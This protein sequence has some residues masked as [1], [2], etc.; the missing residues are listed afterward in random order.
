[1]GGVVLE[2][3]GSHGFP[4]S[5]LD[6]RGR[7]AMLER[8]SRAGGRASLDDLDRLVFT[9]WRRAYKQREE[10]GQEASWTGFLD[11][12][13]RTAGCQIEDLVLLEAWFEPYGEQL[14]PVAGA[15]AALHELSAAGY[16]L[17]LVS[18][19]PL[20]GELYL[21]VLR[22][23]GIA[24]VFGVTVFSYDVHSRKPSPA[25]LRQAMAV[26][27]SRPESTVMVGDRRERD[28]AAGRSAGIAT[29]WIRSADSPGPR[30]DAELESLAG[31][32]GL[33]GE[34]GDRIAD[35]GD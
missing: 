29:V 10:T 4:D 7:Q 26:L 12:L 31:L 3:A 34:W 5:R 35:H 13:R 1:M 15:A 22:R 28:V 21:G 20:P 25:L 27:A 17:G 30:A 23:H 32:P 9:P 14:Q 6:W 8:I 11:R 2:M 33:L 16:R 18:N 24:S 19:V